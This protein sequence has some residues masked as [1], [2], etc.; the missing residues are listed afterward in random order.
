MANRFPRKPLRSR[1]VTRRRNYVWITTSE[2]ST[3]IPGATV[4]MEAIVGADWETLGTFER[5]ATIQRCLVT[6]CWAP[7]QQLTL[8]PVGIYEVGSA[9]IMQ[10]N[11]EGTINI[12]SGATLGVEDFWGAKRQL[13]QVA[14]IGL[15]AGFLGTNVA[16]HGGQLDDDL[17][18]QRKLTDTQ[19][20]HYYLRNYTAS[21]D[22]VEFSALTRVLLK[23]PA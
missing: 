7:V 22:E 12:E 4:R 8:F 17:K 11:D 16:V 21:Q 18:V 1:T 19:V 20:L 3:Q 9:W 5:G 14:G 6:C 2:R 10:D 23:L 13:M 15:T